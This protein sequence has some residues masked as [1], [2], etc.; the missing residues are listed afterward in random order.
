MAVIQHS[1]IT[2]PNIHEPKGASSASAET[3]YVADGAGS[4]SW[5]KID[6][7]QLNEADIDAYIEGKINDQ[8]IDITGQWYQT[9][10]IE[11]VSTASFVMVPVRKNCTVL[12]ARAV[13]ANGITSADA[14][15]TFT[16]SD[17]ASLGTL[18][19]VQAGSAEGTGFS[20]TPSGNETI[21]AP[22]YIKIATNGNS[23][24]A[25]ALYITLEFEGVVNT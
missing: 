18:T 17:A 15:L 11:D 1:A 16:R 12:G 13:L 7:D 25:A 9:V 20:F 3:V 23:D 8:S 24:T 19:I 21:T 14:T 22:N 2:D 4:G 5:Q 6:S 10:V